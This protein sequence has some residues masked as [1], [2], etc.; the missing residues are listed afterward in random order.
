MEAALPYFLS[1]VENYINTLLSLVPNQVG[2]DGV[3]KGQRP[4][5]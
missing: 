4:L 1:L 5:I 2:T 3:G